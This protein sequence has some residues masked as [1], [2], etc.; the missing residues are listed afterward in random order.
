[1]YIASAEG[2]LSRTS[3]VL[4]LAHRALSSCRG[5]EEHEPLLADISSV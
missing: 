1:L 5:S 3:S 2:W 4:G